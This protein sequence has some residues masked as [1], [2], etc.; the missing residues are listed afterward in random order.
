MVHAVWKSIESMKEERFGK[1][2]KKDVCKITKGMMGEERA[3]R[4]TEDIIWKKRELR[5][6]AR[7]LRG[8][9]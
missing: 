7:K 5:N 9:R 2:R 1:V 4:R 8:M 6:S 3:S